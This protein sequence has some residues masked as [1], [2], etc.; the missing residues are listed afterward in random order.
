MCRKLKKNQ[1]KKVYERELRKTYQLMCFQASHIE[2]ELKLL[3]YCFYTESKLT[4]FFYKILYFKKDINLK[5]LY[6]SILYIT[7]YNI[8]IFKI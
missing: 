4:N 6:F 2:K 3:L 8:I 5:I 7:F 1:L